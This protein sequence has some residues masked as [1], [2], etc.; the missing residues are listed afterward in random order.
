MDLLLTGCQSNTPA[1]DTPVRRESS[2]AE[3][4]PAAVASTSASGPGLTP[5]QRLML[6][7]ENIEGTAA[8]ETVGQPYTYLHIQTW[9]RATNAI[10]RTDL[11]RWRHDADGSGQEIVRRLPELAG[12]THRPGRDEPKQLAHAPET[13]TRHLANTLHPYL[14]EPL[15]TDAG[16]LAGALAPRELAAEPAYPRMLAGGIVTLAASQYLDREQRATVLRVLA[17]VP[18]ITYLG[19]TSD[20]VGRRGLG[21]AV[22][23]DGSTS[24]LVIDPRNGEILA[25]REELTERRP[26]LFSYVLILERGR[27]NG[28]GISARP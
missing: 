20:V 27:T 17:S 28:A 13:S 24:Q 21:F 2:A 1:G 7:A 12:V 23:A 25:A 22:S 26:G 16:T 19:H 9:A 3:S 10:T 5:Q 11:R 14:P 6:L 15:P 18:R 8:D 4:Q